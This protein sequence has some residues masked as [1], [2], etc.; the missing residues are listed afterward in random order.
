MLQPLPTGCM[1]RMTS[2][3]QAR[4]YEAVGQHV[5]TH[6]EWRKS[7][8]LT[9]CCP[10][11]ACQPE[12]TSLQ[13]RPCVAV[14]VSSQLVMLAARAARGLTSLPSA[15][16]RSACALCGTSLVDLQHHRC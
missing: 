15:L 7:L 6:L 12:P 11:G 2:A 8:S 13:A 16:T 1:R 9:H 4:E 5:R 14:H 10:S 3:A